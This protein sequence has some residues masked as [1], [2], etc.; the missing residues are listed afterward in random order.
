MMKRQ[1]MKHYYVK[2]QATTTTK[3]ILLLTR[4]WMLLPGQWNNLIFLDSQLRA[5]WVQFPSIFKSSYSLL[6]SCVNNE[7]NPASKFKGFTATPLAERFY[8]NPFYVIS[9]NIKK[10]KHTS[11][12]NLPR[13]TPWGTSEA[14][15]T[16][17]LMTL[18]IF[19]I[20]IL[21]CLWF[22]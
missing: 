21:V 8:K 12:R 17:T 3:Q 19:F 1:S 18:I 2:K 9:C 11:V 4:K 5:S 7:R 6:P 14:H 15:V 22:Y 10:Y 16:R 13:R 20:F